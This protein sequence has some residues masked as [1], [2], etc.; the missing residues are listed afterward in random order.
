MRGAGR[1]EQEVHA[2]EA[3]ERELDHV[4]DGSASG[5]IDG[6]RERLGAE[7]VDLLSRF[8][9]T[10]LVDIGANDVGA[11]ARENQRGGAADAAA[12]PCN[13]DGLPVKVVWRFRHW[14]SPAVHLLGCHGRAWPG[15]P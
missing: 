2:A 14:L 12:G 15:H 3:V 13:D 1:I 9:D 5:D 7:R 8:L 10:L 6:E 11:L 4:L